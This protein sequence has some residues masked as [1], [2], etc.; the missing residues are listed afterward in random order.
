MTLTSL[1]R[2]LF[3]LVLSVTNPTSGSTVNPALRA[4]YRCNPDHNDPTVNHPVPMSC[5]I[6]VIQ[7]P[8]PSRGVHWDHG[9]NG[10]IVY[11]HPLTSTGDPRSPYHLPRQ[12]VASRCRVKVE[13]R[14]GVQ[15]VDM[16]WS[17]IRIFALTLVR[18][19]VGDE[20]IT[21]GRRGQGTGGICD[22][23]AV[24]ITVGAVGSPSSSSDSSWSVSDPASD[25]SSWSSLGSTPGD[26]MDTTA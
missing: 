22:L 7:L 14:P 20:R 5:A 17:D 16:V 19:C 2:Y 21:P 18:R 8:E 24:R 4:T 15:S 26:R 1:L 12:S 6:A 25:P 3:L 11:H 23:D 10:V 9:H 13:L